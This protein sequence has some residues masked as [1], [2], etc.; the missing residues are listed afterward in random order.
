MR[1]LEYNYTIELPD[2]WSQDGEDRYSRASSSA[3]LAIS[4]QLLPAGYTV[5][6]FSQFVRDD[7]QKDWWPNAS[8]F[9]ITSVEEGL[10]D[11]QLAMSILY[12]VQ[13]SPEYCVLDVEE[14][15]V[16]S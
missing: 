12:R 1:E 8:L 14:L 13:E 9:E 15:V 4:S 3:R 11:N 7:L 6:Q 5:D 16:V 2:G 10:A